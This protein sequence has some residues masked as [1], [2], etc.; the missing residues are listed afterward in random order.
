MEHPGIA[1][2]TLLALGAL[3][4]LLSVLSCAHTGG[5]GESKSRRRTTAAPAPDSVTVALWRMDETNGARITD[6]GPFRLSGTAGVATNPGYG[7]IEGAREFTRA[8][9]SFVLVPTNPV[10]DLAAGFTLEMWVYVR[11]IGQY[12]MTPLASRWTQQGNQQSWLF[13]IGGQYLQAPIANLPSPGYL[14]ALVRPGS[15]SR[16]LFAFQPADASI[17][18]VYLSTQTLELERWTHVA[19]TYE[20]TIVRFYID[21]KLDSQYASPGRIASSIAPL[22]IGNYIDPRRLSSFGGDLRV[23]ANGDNNPYYAFEGSIDELRISSTARTEFPEA[24]GR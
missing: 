17:P 20:G 22:L 13:A 2:R 23:D 14:N 12:E 15:P 8:I 21:G 11:S 6:A 1:R 16:L 4:L 7:R 24:L 5:A 10:L 19:V 3:A 9:D 18:R